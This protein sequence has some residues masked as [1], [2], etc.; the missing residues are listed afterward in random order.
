M[1]DFRTSK[2]APLQLEISHWEADE[3][4]KVSVQFLGGGDRSVLHFGVVLTNLL[5]LLGDLA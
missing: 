4:A 5:G 3:K 2:V 1:L